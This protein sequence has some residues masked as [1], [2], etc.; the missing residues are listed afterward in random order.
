MRAVFVILPE[1]G[2]VQQILHAFQSSVNNL[3]GNKVPYD[4]VAQI[5]RF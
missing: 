1:P 4:I 5:V 3:Q 2:C